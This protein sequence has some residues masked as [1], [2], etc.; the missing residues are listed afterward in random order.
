MRRRR[1]DRTGP[2]CPPDPARRGRRRPGSESKSPAPADSGEPDSESG[3]RARH[4]PAGRDG[5]ARAIRS[6][7]ASELRVSSWAQ[8]L[9][10]DWPGGA[11]DA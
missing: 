9:S 3:T 7:I 10:R 8:P 11:G 5:A 4:L 2:A 6:L 1:G